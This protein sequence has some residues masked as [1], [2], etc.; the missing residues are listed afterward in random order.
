MP[1]DE[2]YVDKVMSVCM[3]VRVHTCAHT[4]VFS[5]FAYLE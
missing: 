4:C 1:W 5:H 2:Q 3:C